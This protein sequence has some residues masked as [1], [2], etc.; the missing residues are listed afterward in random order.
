PGTPMGTL[1]RRYWMP[2]MLSS[3]VE[4]D[5]VVRKIRLLGEDLIAWRDSAGRPAVIEENC[6]HRGSSLLL[7]RNEEDGLRC[8]YHGWKFDVEG[9]CTDMPSEPS[10][11]NFR[12]K[13][14]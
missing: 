13:V 4:P 12:E 8:V 9:R 5:G 10:S 6:P 3:E 2:A 7:G 11:S 1:L 14:R